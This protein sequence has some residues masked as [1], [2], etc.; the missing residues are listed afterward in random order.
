MLGI[1]TKYILV[2]EVESVPQY[3][4]AETTKGGK[5]DTAFNAA[6]AWTAFVMPTTFGV[7]QT[8]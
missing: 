7:F 6:E 1:H 8:G 4:L 2:T 3:H 5:Q